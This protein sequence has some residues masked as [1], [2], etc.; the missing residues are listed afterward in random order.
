MLR[1]AVGFTSRI[2]RFCG[3]PAGGGVFVRE[4][5]IAAKTRRFFLAEALIGEIRNGQT[6]IFAA[7]V[8]EPSWRFLCE[9][10]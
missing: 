6:A 7:A 2:S 10:T 4:M 9:H 1:A 3:T 8:F 5:R